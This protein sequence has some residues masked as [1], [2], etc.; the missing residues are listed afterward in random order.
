MDF[1]LE[2]TFDEIKAL[3]IAFRSAS[4]RDMLDRFFHEHRNLAKEGYSEAIVLISQD[5]I[6][7]LADS[8]GYLLKRNTSEPEI[9]KMDS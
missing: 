3:S 7:F 5:D 8:E 9:K 4:F 6:G 1:N 2:L